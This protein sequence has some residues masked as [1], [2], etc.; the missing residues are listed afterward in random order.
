MTM[1]SEPTPSGAP[2]LENASV[3]A[4]LSQLRH[5]TPE[6]GPPP[7]DYVE[8]DDVFDPLPTPED[9]D[10]EDHVWVEEFG[11][12][13]AIEVGRAPSQAR[14]PNEEMEG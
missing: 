9:G 6:V 10:V 12:S 13:F 2:E 14:V 11:E 1:S 4:S 7:E 3:D 5:R 8:N